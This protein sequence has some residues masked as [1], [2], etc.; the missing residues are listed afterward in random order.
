MYYRVCVKEKYYFI[1]NL[2]KL[3]FLKNEDTTSWP[4]VVEELPLPFTGAIF[5]IY[6]HHIWDSMLGTHIWALQQIF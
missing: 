6:S 2:P 5:W 4:L 3:D 1:P